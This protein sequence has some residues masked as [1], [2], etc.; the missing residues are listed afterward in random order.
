MNYI[1][2]INSFFP[3]EDANTNCIMPFIN[4]IQQSNC[5]SIVTKGDIDDKK[6]EIIKGVKVYR[7]TLNKITVIFSKLIKAIMNENRQSIFAERIFNCLLL[8][9]LIPWALFYKIFF[10]IQSYSGEIECAK[11]IKNSIDNLNPD[12]IISVNSPSYPHYAVYILSKLGILKRRNIKWIAYYMDP[13]ATYKYARKLTK[14][15]KYKRETRIYKYADRIMMPPEMYQENIEI[16][17][18]EYKQKMVSINFANLKKL[19]STCSRSEQFD[20]DYIECS[21]VGSLNNSKIRNPE[22]FIRLL[23]LLNNKKIRI[24]IIGNVSTPIIDCINRIT[25]DDKLNILIHGRMSL[26]DSINYI[27]NSDILINIGNNCSNQLPSKVFDYIASG[28]P[29]VNF[30]THEKD[31]SKKYLS[32]YPLHINLSS[33]LNDSTLVI[34]FEKFC[35]TNKNQKIEYAVIQENYKQNTSENAIKIFNEIITD[36]I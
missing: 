3:Y 23:G 10:D 24:H 16:Y 25:K 1:I 6:I 8:I 29:I 28:K 19:E 34:E 18:S 22:T 21:Y 26:E 17:Y 14:K 20:G 32:K 31:T 9:F 27:A 36:I 2:V 7:F 4:A 11:K 13:D 15:S 33:S 30:Y 12:V 35:L 5:V